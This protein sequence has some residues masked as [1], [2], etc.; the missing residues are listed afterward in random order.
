MALSILAAPLG[1][2][3]DGFLDDDLD[4][5]FE[6][7]SDARVYVSYLRNRS[8]TH[9]TIPSTV[10]YEYYDS[11]DRDDNGNAKLK[12]RTCTVT[13]IDSG[14]FYGFSGLTSV[15]IPDSVTSIGLSAF[16]GC[17]GL[18]SVTIP[19]SVTSIGDYAFQDCS[20][21]TSVTIPDS[22][23]SI[24]YQA[25]YNCS[26]L[27]SVTIPDSVTSIGSYAFSGCSWLTS[28]T[29]PDSV[30]SIGNGAFSN[31]SRLTTVWIG[32]GATDIHYTAFN[33]CENVQR[34]IVDAENP[35]YASPDGALCSKDLKTLVVYPRGRTDAR[36]PDSLVAAMPDAFAGC[37]KL[38]ME[39]CKRINT[40]PYDLTQ[41]PGDRAIADVT[42]N[43]D[44]ALDA[45]VLKE[46][47]VYDSVLY[48]CN[49]ADHAVKVTLPTIPQTEYKTFKGATPLTLPA[50]S[51]SIL[52]ITRVAGGNAG[53]NVFLV[54][55]EEL[56]TVK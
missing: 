21:L 5:E 12:R 51:T 9:I 56:E 15:T 30:T 45:F 48:V 6:S 35:A 49:N 46:G 52:T 16:Y 26:G 34:F 27:T 19:D 39:W 43:G 28:V 4:Y 11:N 37:N 24:G 7:G 3:A 23:T 20:G 2:R 29:I 54:T 1:V 53:G 14:A 31:C 32:S 50:H 47:K 55:R 22:V 8:A 18:T 40:I 25:F 13:S 17:S 33:L 36:L 42:V 41:T 44:M 10:V 38:W